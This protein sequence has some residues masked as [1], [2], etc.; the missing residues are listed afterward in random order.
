M[1]RRN[2]ATPT[3]RDLPD[4]VHGALRMQ[5]ARHGRRMEAEVLEILE[6][7]VSYGEGE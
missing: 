6:S 1:R 7:A 3:L 4:P 5:A 2:V